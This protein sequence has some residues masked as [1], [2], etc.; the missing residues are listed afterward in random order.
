MAYTET[1]SIGLFSRLRSSFAGMGVGFLLFLAGTALLWW[2][3]GD[4]VATRDA[5]N[6]AQG[7]AREMPDVTRVDPAFNGSLVHATAP[8]DTRDVVKDP[9]F[10]ISERAIRLERRVQFYQWTEHSTKEKRTKLGGGEETVTTYTYKREWVD[11]PVDSSSFRDPDARMNHV[12]GVLLSVG[13]EDFMAASVNF[14]AYVLPLFLAKTIDGAQPYRVTLAP[15]RIEALTRQMLNA[16]PSSRAAR[17]GVG[18]NP[19]RLVHEANDTIYLGASPAQPAVGDV[20]VSFKLIPPSQTVSVLA[21]VN[22]NTFEQFHAANGKR[23]SALAMGAVSMEEMFGDKHESNVFWTWIFRALGAVMIIIALK[24]LMAPLAVIASVIPL[25]GSIVNAGAGLVSSLLGIAWSLVIM[26]I[27][28]LRFRPMIGG[29][30]LAVAVVLVA[31]LLLKGR[32]RNAQPA[33][34]PL[35]DL[36]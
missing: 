9:L 12:N 21:R 13:K 1:A 30:M 15:E 20:R 23:V 24:M 17:A 5:L 25:F 32:G 34:A 22:G 8:A 35:S 10:G 18:K 16:R 33:S 3:E 36:K 27:A 4:F 26:A 29:I 7:I 6:E 2:N 28:W 31:I 14:G 11:A 19:P